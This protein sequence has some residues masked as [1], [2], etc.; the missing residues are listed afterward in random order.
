VELYN[1]CITSGDCRWEKLFLKNF[2]INI[3]NIIPVISMCLLLLFFPFATALIA[4]S[5]NRNFWLWFLIGTVLPFAGIAILLCLRI[6]K[7]YTENEM[8][9]LD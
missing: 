7:G 8:Y 4:K 2:K 1:W 9:P 5:L 3:V 6:K